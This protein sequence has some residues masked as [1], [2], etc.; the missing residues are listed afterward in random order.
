MWDCTFLTMGQKLFAGGTWEICFSFCAGT[1]W[2]NLFIQMQY[3]V[4][5]CVH[6]SNTLRS[7]IPVTGKERK[8]AELM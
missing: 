7:N 4:I 6:F 5:E 3:P 1:G 2:T 8:K